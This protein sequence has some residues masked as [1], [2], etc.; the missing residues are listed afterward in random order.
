MGGLFARGGAMEGVSFWR[1]CQRGDVSL[2]GGH[3]LMI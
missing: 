1:G 2:A 3:A